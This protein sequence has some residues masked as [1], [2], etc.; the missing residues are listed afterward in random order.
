M[1]KDRLLVLS[2]YSRMGASS[3]LRTMQYEPWLEEAGFEVEYS[4]LFD[5]K[6]LKCLYSGQGSKI[7]FFKYYF[8]RI[9]QLR[10]S[11]QFKLIWIEYEALPWL[12]WFV[13]RALLPSAVSIVS[14]YDDA[15]FHRYDQHRSQF[16]KKFLG[17]KINNIMR[18]SKL[19]TV[20]NGY[21]AN[22][23]RNACSESVMLIPTVVNLSQYSQNLEFCKKPAVKIG[24][25]GTPN[26]WLTFG[27]EKYNLLQ[28]TLI[29]NNAI[30][31][32]V[33]AQLHA[34]RFGILEMIPWSEGTEV[35][36]ILSMDIGIM[37]LDN[38]AW[39]KGKCGY[40]LIQY[41]ACGLP[42]VASPI[43][44]NKA[45]VEHGVSGFLAE[46]DEEWLHYINILLSDKDLRHR[47]GSAGRKKVEKEY[48]LQVWGPKVAS[49]LRQ[50]TDEAK[51]S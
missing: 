6:Y 39:S 33:G 20:G 4:A 40:K 12:P 32:A 21:L 1:M 29:S 36:D 44:V 10:R 17:Q 14:D 45:I 11:A 41:M 8:K 15:I 48:S 47:M 46:N 22:H 25:I 51:I 7:D 26:T 23:A 34:E 35:N 13:E 24:W 50:I 27:K 38:S 9:V 28:E 18:Y 2:R 3:R 49:M 5:D 19:V 43:G 42:V 37:P 31:A 16:V 30:F